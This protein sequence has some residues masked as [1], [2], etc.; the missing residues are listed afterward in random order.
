MAEM[1]AVEDALRPWL[2][3]AFLERCD[4]CM[5]ALALL[6][7]FDAGSGD[8]ESLR[9]RLDTLLFR[10]VR[11]MTEGDMRVLLDDGRVVRVRVDDISQMADELLYLALRETPRTPWHYQ[12]L[13]DY[14][15][16]HESLAALR[17]LYVDLRAF[18]SA[19]ELA[20]IART[21]RMCYPPFRW[22]GWLT[23]D[24]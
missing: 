22:Q 16:T 12:R 4:V 1:R 2:G 11:A 24:T 15:L 13:R 3:A 19:D 9:A 14:A 21:A 5:R 17:A 8:I 18:Q 10:A 7:A 6:R 23:E 20:L